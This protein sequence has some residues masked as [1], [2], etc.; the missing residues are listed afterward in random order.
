MTD[1]SPGYEY[2]K[3]APGSQLAPYIQF[4]Y[5][6]HS[7][8]Q[9]QER[10]LPLSYA[11]ISISLSDQ[12]PKAYVL[13]PGAGSYFIIPQSLHQVIGICF[14]PWG[15]HKFLGIPTN[16]L[17][18]RKRAIQDVLPPLQTAIT[19]LLEGQTNVTTIVHL[20]R[21]FLISKIKPSPH[22][23]IADAIRF[24]HAH[25]G[26]APLT[27]L[28]QRYG[29]S[30]RKL[31]LLFEESIGL[32]PKKYSRL[33]RFHYAVSQLPTAQGLTSLALDLGY[34]DQ[35]HF[36][37]EFKAFAGISPKNFLKESNQLNAI[38]AQSWF[39]D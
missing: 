20:L 12:G 21:Q 4:F 18:N 16:Q 17:E 5:Y 39:S 27:D 38:N 24:I 34:Y 37:H 7:I 26:Q 11:E 35:S 10:I 32:S 15:I 29:Y 25:N 33:K 31:Q 28:Y 30:T 6:F 9:K 8:A 22:P 13:P 36:I 14:Q 2:V 1:A 19:Q 23:F 3:F